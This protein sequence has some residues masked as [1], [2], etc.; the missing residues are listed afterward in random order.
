MGRSL[1]NCCAAHWLVYCKAS[2]SMAVHCCHSLIVVPLALVCHSHCRAGWPGGRQ[3]AHAVPKVHRDM[4][5][6]RSVG[7]SW[8]LSARPSQRTLHGV[9]RACRASTFAAAGSV[10]HAALGE[11]S[12]ADAT[13]PRTPS[14][15]PS[16]A[17]PPSDPALRLLHA[18]CL[19]WSRVTRAESKM[20]NGRVSLSQ[21]SAG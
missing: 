20:N 17:R 11:T 10:P 3:R 15:R 13:I 21:L 16:N 7:R 1:S 18:D 9:G 2:S 6:C 14:F 19:R 5:R 8:V 4:G 12:E